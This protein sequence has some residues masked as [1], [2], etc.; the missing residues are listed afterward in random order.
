MIIRDFKVTDIDKGLLELYQ[1]VW[2][3]SKIDINS[4][5]NF[6]RNNN[7]M[8]VVEENDVI[9]GSL[10]LHLQYK[11]IRDGGIAGFIEDVVISENFRGNGIGKLLVK[12]AIE[13][14]KVLNCYKIVLSCFDE[15]VNF[16]ES[17]GFRVENKTM[18]LDI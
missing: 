13:K 14:A 18:R 12:K 7:Y 4:L 16:Y 6:I 15:R 1:Q 9:I 2:K 11:L 10:V 5:R 8:I 3:V 17:C